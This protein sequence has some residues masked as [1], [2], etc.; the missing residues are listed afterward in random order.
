MSENC[1][2][3]TT[4]AAFTVLKEMQNATPFHVSILENSFLSPELG[5]Q[6]VEQIRFRYP[7]LQCWVCAPRMAYLQ[8]DALVACGSAIS[9]IS[10]QKYPLTGCRPLPL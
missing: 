5:T 3:Q 6:H 7:C 1:P 4:N 8:R 2:F 10:V 9:A